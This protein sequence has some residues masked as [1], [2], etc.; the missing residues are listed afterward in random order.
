MTY[1]VDKTGTV[2]VVTVKLH[3]LATTMQCPV[4]GGY[5]KLCSC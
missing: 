3:Y 1:T 5:T 4:C 2:T